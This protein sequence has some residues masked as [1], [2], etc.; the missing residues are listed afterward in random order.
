MNPDPVPQL[1]DR[2]FFFAARA[3]RTAAVGKT[4]KTLWRVTR[5]R[6]RS[7]LERG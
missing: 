5:L 3:V 2:V 4:A 1:K 6:L 7:P